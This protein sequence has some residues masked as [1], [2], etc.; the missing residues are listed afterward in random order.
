MNLWDGF[1]S[2]AKNVN[3]YKGGGGMNENVEGVV[4]VEMSE[5]T[6]DLSDQE[7]ISLK[8]KWE[9]TWESSDLKSSVNKMQ[10]ENE[11][12]WK[13]EQFDDENPKRPLADNIIF[14][15]VETFLPILTRQKPEP[16]VEA[17]NTKDGNSLAYKVQKMLVYQSDRLRMK[18]K[19]Q[20]LTRFWML[21]LLGVVKVGWNELENDIEL[22]VLRPQKLILDPEATIDDGV[23]RGEYIGEYRKDFAKDLIK[24]FP[25]KEKYIRDLVNDKLG[26]H[27]QY[28][29]W[30]TNEYVFWTLKDE[31]LLKAKNPHWNYDGKEKTVDEYGNELEI[32]KKGNNHFS[33]PKKPYIFLTVYDL[34]LGPFDSTS[35][36]QQ[37]LALQDLINKRLKQID[38]NADNT[39]GGLLISGDHF[40]KEQAAQVAEGLRSGKPAWVPKGRVGDAINR[41][42]AP[43]LP[44][45]IYQSL[46][47]YRGE[48]RNIFGVRG[49]S[50]QGI[51]NEETVRGKILIKGQLS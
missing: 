3:K 2:L 43:P 5:L 10:D 9:K 50:P 29:E 32:E 15:A 7:L 40:D 46:Q 27:V 11:K 35:I 25:K 24:R 45:F 1:N 18:L 28:I 4:S 47:D 42:I 8:K 38:K 23:Y 39:N 14:E 22:V 16:I 17:N 21:Y 44:N 13:G 12:Y 36:I 6:L 26:T 19:I 41:T 31:V 30:W 51:L 33:T 48:L 37:N 34:N 20:K 49:A